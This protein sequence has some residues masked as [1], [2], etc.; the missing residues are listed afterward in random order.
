MKFSE[1]HVRLIKD[2]LNHRIIE[3]LEGTLKGHVV[4]FPCNEQG[5]LQW[6]SNRTSTVIFARF[7]NVQILI[8]ILLTLIAL[9]EKIIKII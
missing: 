6:P 5:H 7:S 9:P 4:Q 1:Q 3:L 8:L 2:A